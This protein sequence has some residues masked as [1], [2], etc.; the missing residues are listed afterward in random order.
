MRLFHVA[1]DSLIFAEETLSFH[2]T[3]YPQPRVASL[4]LVIK[5]HG[6]ETER[7]RANLR[8]E[9]SGIC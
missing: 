3:G 2:Q 9:R 8:Q 7:K 6:L 1:G 4:G 5:K